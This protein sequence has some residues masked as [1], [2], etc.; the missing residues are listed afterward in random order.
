VTTNNTNLT[1]QPKD[2]RG[3]RRR[4]QILFK[5][6]LYAIVGAGFE[7]YDNKGSGFLEA[8]YQGCLKIELE[9]RGIPFLAPAALGLTYEGWPS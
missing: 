5:D 3:K 4:M 6:D 2:E 8:V 9:L 7:V 1:D